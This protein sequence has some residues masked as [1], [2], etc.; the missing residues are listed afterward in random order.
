[1]RGNI[2]I[3]KFLLILVGGTLLG[4]LVLGGIGFL[5]AGR[6]GFINMGSWG[7]AL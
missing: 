1:M 6:E 4:G 5:L 7:L 3:V 2:S